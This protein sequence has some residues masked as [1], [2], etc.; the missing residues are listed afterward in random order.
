[1]S[2]T[3][4][5][6]TVAVPMDLHFQT[7]HVHSRRTLPSIPTSAIAINNDACHRTCRLTLREEEAADAI[8]LDFLAAVCSPLQGLA[9][10]NIIH[11]QSVIQRLGHAAAYPHATRR[12]LLRGDQPIGRLMFDCTLGHSR[13]VDVAI[14]PVTRG[15]GYGTW[16]LTSW[17]QVA[18]RLGMATSLRVRRDN[19][20]IA[21]Y[22]RLGF[23]AGSDDGSPMATMTRT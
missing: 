18:D 19:P 4:K 17:L 5:S 21:L 8:F 7:R 11:Q 3:A 16:L 2:Q 9:S 22:Q 15:L 14:L 12:I 10:D 13:C 23:V 20:A 1:M 6:S